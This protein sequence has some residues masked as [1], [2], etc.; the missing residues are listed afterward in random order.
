MNKRRLALYIGIAITVTG[1]TGF[2][3]REK[4]MADEQYRAYV[5]S[6]QRY[7]EAMTEDIYGG[8][9][10]DETLNL[11]ITSLEAGDIELASKYFILS[12][13]LSR[14]KW[15]RIFTIFKEQG[16]LDEVVRDIEKDPNLLELKLNGYSGVWKIVNFR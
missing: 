4:F 14:D 12:S 7:A 1:L 2:L 6:E 5:E 3:I 11:F 8:K 15:V 16:L 9:T 10:S 13:D